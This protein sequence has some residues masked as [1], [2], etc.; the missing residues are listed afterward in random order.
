MKIPK[1][2]QFE[3]VACLP[4]PLERRIMAMVNKNI[5]QLILNKE[6]KK[7]AVENAKYS[8]V[9]DLEDTIQIKYIA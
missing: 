7:K 3:Y 6:E 9:C 1:Q 2:Y 8:K 5:S 4:H